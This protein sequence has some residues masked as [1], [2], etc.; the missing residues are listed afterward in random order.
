[1][2][3]I[4][5]VVSAV[6]VLS[7][8]LGRAQDPSSERSEP[9]ESV[10]S[11]SSVSKAIEKLPPIMKGRWEANSYS[12]DWNIQI[13]QQ[14]ADGSCSGLFTFWGVRYTVSNIP[15]TCT[16]DGKTLSSHLKV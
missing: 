8:L 9:K 15:M 11:N 7:P 3:R 5:A 16:Y 4:I 13:K 12:G 10:S 6:S 1:M 14:L 2:K